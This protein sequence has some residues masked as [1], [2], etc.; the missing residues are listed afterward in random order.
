MFLIRKW[1]YRRGWLTAYQTLLCVAVFSVL[2]ARQVVPAFPRVTPASAITHG[3]RHHDQRP[4]FDHDGLYWCSV[5]QSFSQALPV[6]RL[7]LP[8]LHPQAFS[9]ID[10]SYYTRPPP[11][12]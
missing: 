2:L 6:R 11:L 1:R 4:C 5:V 10:R 8:A 9:S 7:S 3:V 12:A